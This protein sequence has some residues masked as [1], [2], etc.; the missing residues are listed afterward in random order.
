MIWVD[1]SRHIVSV[2]ENVQPCQQGTCPWHG[3]TSDDV[4]YLIQTEAGFIQRQALTVGGELK[5]TLH[6]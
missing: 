1:E 4:R 6:M 2:M 5:Y 3:S